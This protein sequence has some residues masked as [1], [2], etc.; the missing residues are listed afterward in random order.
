MNNSCGC[1]GCF[2][3]VIIALILGI[4]SWIGGIICG[5]IIAIILG[6]GFTLNSIFRK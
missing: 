5:I 1:V 6:I 3:Y 4:F 2:I